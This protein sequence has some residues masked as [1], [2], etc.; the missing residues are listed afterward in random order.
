MNNHPTMEGNKLIKKLNKLS[1]AVILVGALSSI[2]LRGEYS[3]SP[4][5]AEQ[6]L[7]GEH[8]LQKMAEQTEVNSKTSASFFLIMGDINTAT[9]TTLSTKFAWE[10]NDGTYAVSSLPLEKIRVKID[11]K[12]T[13]P[14]IKFRWARSFHKGDLQQLMDNSVSYA[15]VTVKESDWPVQVNPPLN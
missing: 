13:M 6:I 7:K 14:T 1:I 4:S 12:V 11:E 2:F 3:Q 9:K 15:V 10:M 8:K 5:P